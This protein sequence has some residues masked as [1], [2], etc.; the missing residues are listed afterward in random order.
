MTP[1]TI[2]T[3]RLGLTPLT[4]SDADEMAGVLADGSLYEYTGGTPPTVADLRGRY[5]AQVAGSGR[6]D[7]AWLNWIIRAAGEPVGYVQATVEVAAAQAWV[8]WVVGTPWQGRGYAAEA[9]AALVTWLRGRGLTVAAAVAPGHRA[10][11]RVAAAAGL[12]VTD[13]LLDGERVWRLDKLV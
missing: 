3:A 11:E 2:T 6:A 9:A 7:E 5:A 13:E 12:A 1:E 10:S 4:V 8:A